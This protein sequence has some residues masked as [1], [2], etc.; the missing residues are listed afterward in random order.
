MIPKLLQPQAQASGGYRRDIDGLR[1]IAVLAVVIF[2]FSESFMPGGYLGVDVFFVLSGYL[3]TGIIV[4]EA[5]EGRFSIARFYERRIRRI[6]PAL[7]FV[8]T[9]TT[10]VSAI[11]LLPLDLEGYGKSL[12]ASLAFVANIYFWRDGNYF[13]QG[14]ETKPLLHIWSLGV[15][16]QFYIF[17]PLLVMLLARRT[18]W[19]F[20]AIAGTVAASLALNIWLLA[21]G[22]ASPAFYLLP[23]RAWELGAGA[24]LV[25][26]PR[27]RLS[28]VAG[29][30]LM[31]V[32]YAVLLAAIVAAPLWVPHPVP[33]PLPAVAA[34]ALLIW[35]GNSERA[36]SLAAPLKIAPMVGVGLISYSLYLWHWPVIVFAKYYL[37]GELGAPVIAALFGVMVLAAWAS[38]RFVEKPFRTK[39]FPVRRLYWIT[40]IWAAMLA[41]AGLAL[42]RFD[43]LPSR[44]PA[45]V[46]VINAAIG[47]HYR[48]PIARTT[49]YDGVRSCWFG[50]G[51][52]GAGG[53]AAAD[54]LLLGNSH[55]QMYAPAVIEREA[56]RGRS[57]LMIP[58]NGCAPL[59]GINI[60]PGCIAIA[61]ANIDAA[62][63]HP[64]AD[65]VVIAFAWHVAPDLVF[66]D[67]SKPARPQ[68]AL[69]S[70]LDKT[71]ERLRA[72]GKRVTVIGPIATPGYDFPS[73]VGR[74]RAF[75][76]EVDSPLAIPFADFQDEFGAYLAAYRGRAGV[77]LLEPHRAQ[78][79][80]SQCNFM[81]NGKSLFA[82][83]THVS[84]DGLVVFAPYLAA[85]RNDPASRASQPG[86]TQ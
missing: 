31:A 16:E 14:S 21:A 51:D 85:N 12:V 19:L 82:D 55:A 29:E 78:C 52:V 64:A 23:A 53:P 22:Y 59:T 66:A 13:A 84:A 74:A 26:L 79:D 8:L 62:V 43:G 24:M 76:R 38:W 81:A 83:K 72:S 33:T 2:H 68:E 25:F 61:E 17:F 7:L 3:I 15:E 49:S 56:A 60:R 42:V 1:A 47:S 54:T 45:N 67:G 11:V 9:A 75:G 10:L 37:V 39:E 27:P 77:T 4:R 69:V 73:V 71:I 34:T 6:A 50:D 28:R 30:A 48:C 5:G 18:G 57:V 44:L 63:N 86:D 36:L 40:G 41:L 65:E 70:G 32:C 35:L 46:G 20:A 80:A 58:A